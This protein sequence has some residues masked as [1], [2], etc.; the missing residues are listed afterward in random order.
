MK[1]DN[2]IFPFYL[3][4]PLLAQ[5]NAP[6]RHPAAGGVLCFDRDQMPLCWYTCFRWAESF[7]FSL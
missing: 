1:T 5:Q 2:L 3:L 7:M 4:F 6:G